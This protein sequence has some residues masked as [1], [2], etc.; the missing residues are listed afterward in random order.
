MPKEVSLKD[1]AFDELKRLAHVRGFPQE[2]RA[3]D[4][5]LYALMTM[6]TF[7]GVTR[8]MDELTQTEWISFPQA[9]AIR[10][11]AYERTEDIRQQ[12]RQCANCGGTGFNTAWFLVTHNGKSLSTKKHERLR[13]VKNQEQADAFSLKVK[14]FLDENPTADRQMVVSATED[15][16]CRKALVAQ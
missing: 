12:R 3:I 11:M 6:E 2:R 1:H 16:A 7:E 5:Y 13:E 10:R 8:L 15:C 14:V 4:D 9:A